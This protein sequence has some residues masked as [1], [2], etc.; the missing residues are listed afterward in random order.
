M[1]YR[2]DIDGLRAIAVFSVIYYHIEI[3]F[4]SSFFRG[5]F[6]G[7]DIFFVISGY[8][9]TLIILKEFHLKFLHDYRQ[10]FH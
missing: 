7:V 3:P 4:L 6:I 10:I 8:L 9:L 2:K 5:G 1:E